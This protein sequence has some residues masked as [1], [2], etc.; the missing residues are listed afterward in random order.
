[1]L[2][3][4]KELKYVFTNHHESLDD[5]LAINR[6]TTDSRL[7]TDHALFIPIIGDQ[8]NGHDYVEQA[9]ENGAVAIVWDE[10]EELPPS[11]PR[12]FPVFFTED[13]TAGLQKLAAYYRDEI[14]PI[15][16]GITGSN[17]KTTTKDLVAAIMKTTYNTH[18]TL[19]NL[20]NHIGLPLTILSMPR[21]TEVLVLELGMSGFG[22]IDVLTKIAKPDYAVITNIGESHIE[23]LGSREGIAKAKLEIINGLKEGGT[24]IVDGDEPLLQDIHTDDPVDIIRC[25]FN[26]DNEFRLRDVDIT[27]GGTAFTDAHGRHLQVPLLGKHHAKNA[28]FALQ[29]AELLHISKEKRE[30]GLQALAHSAMR[31]E[32]LKSKQHQ[33]TVVNDSYNASPTSMKA[34]IEV[35]K[36]MEGFDTKILVLGD[37][38]ELGEYADQL[39]RSI[40]D[41]I[42]SPITH[43]YTYGEKAKLIT[44]NVQDSEIQCKHF[45]TKEA[46]MSELNQ[47]L[48]EMSL[49]LFKASRGLQFETMVEDIVMEQEDKEQ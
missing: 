24:L 18:A 5:S 27:V 13:T 12:D 40:A 42:S 32:L 22:E 29:I 47:H 16:I 31:F 48:T 25:G 14:N 41:V 44:E 45:G 7:K 23:Y 11:I 10:K 8:L 33:A 30:A 36:Q 3:T 38:L 20:N 1:M 43:L 34:A 26:A 49:V 19:G 21:D 4:V 6:I 9:I 46:L 28:G 39:H 2:F 37:V 15:V 35:I 17:G